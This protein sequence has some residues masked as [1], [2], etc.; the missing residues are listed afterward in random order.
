M[1][2]HDRYNRLCTLG[3]T[4]SDLGLESLFKQIP[5]TYVN[6][7]K[8]LGPEKITALSCNITKMKSFLENQFAP[9]TLDHEI[10]NNFS[11]GQKITL[12]DTRELLKVIYQNNDI[13][14]TANAIDLNNYF[15][16]SKTRITVALGDGTKK[17]K[18]G[19]RLIKK[20][21]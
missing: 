13:Q 20:L 12:Q 3:P 7:Y 9:E 1:T 17:V 19:L 15:T 18:D 8:T 4:L 6:Y 16:T 2:V 21:R 14:K 10:Y 11:E 5:I